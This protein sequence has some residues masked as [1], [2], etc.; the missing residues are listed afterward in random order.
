MDNVLKFTDEVFEKFSERLGS[1]EY[2]DFI[3]KTKASDEDTGTFK[4]IISTEDFDRA[5]ESIKINA[6]DL[7]NYKNNPVVLWGHSHMQLPIGVATSVKKE[8]TNLVARGKFASHEF[9]QTIRKMYDM[10]IVRATSVGFI[11]K[12]FDET[13]KVITKAELLEF[14]FVSVPMNP[15]ALSQLSATDISINSLISKG[16]FETKIVD[17]APE[18]DKKEEE[19]EDAPETP[20][21]A[22]EGEEKEEDEETPAG[23]EKEPTEEKDSEDEIVKEEEKEEEKKN[24]EVEEEKTLDDVYNK[25]GDLF[26]KL[27]AVEPKLDKFIAFQESKDADPKGNEEGDDF[28]SFKENREV[29]QKASTIIGDVL[30]EARKG[31]EAKKE[32]N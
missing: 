3:S 22:T 26:D 15:N 29:L 21:T 30:A 17:S 10:G 7:K 19:P 1:D 23:E 8:G 25:I 31:F 20:E 9:A 32:Q 6:W 4:V 13:G 24:E 14:S 16:I 28:K 27:E 12:E 5:G 2:Q 11:P 18:E